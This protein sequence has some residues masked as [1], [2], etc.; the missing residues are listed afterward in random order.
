MSDASGQYTIPAHNLDDSYMWYA[1]I[2]MMIDGQIWSLPTRIFYVPVLQVAVDDTS[3]TPH[4]K[5]HAFHHAALDIFLNNRKIERI[6]LQNEASKIYI[7]KNLT[8]GQTYTSFVQLVDA[9]S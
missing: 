1:A 9:D 5:I 3:H 4:L 7:F 6:S 8:S 2:H